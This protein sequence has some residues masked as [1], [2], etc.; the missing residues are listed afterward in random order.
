MLGTTLF[1]M[2]VGVNLIVA[3]LVARW[4]VLPRLRA[5]PLAEALLPLVLVH[6]LRT[7]GVVFVLPQV[8]GG[9]LPPGFAVP[10]AVGDLLVVILAAVAIVALRRGWRMAFS[11]VWILNVVGLLDFVNAFVQGLRYDIA[12]Q[13]QLG[14][15]WFI[16]TFFV[17]AF[18]VIHIVMIYLLITQPERQ[19]VVLRGSA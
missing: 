19:A 2:Q 17:P 9:S 12:A 5:L 16:P 3:A 1:A 14:P 6:L 11:L 18:F 4:Y 7:M 13:Y 8:V 10:G 15:A